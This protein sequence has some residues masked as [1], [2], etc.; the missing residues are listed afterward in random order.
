MVLCCACLNHEV[1]LE[2]AYSES[3]FYVERY[4]VKPLSELDFMRCRWNV[5]HRGEPYIG[6]GHWKI[7][8]L[9]KYKLVSQA[10]LFGLF[11]KHW[12]T[13]FSKM[14]CPAMSI[15]QMARQKCLNDVYRINVSQY[16]LDF[17]QSISNVVK[18]E[19]LVNFF[20]E[21]HDRLAC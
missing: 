15:T 14:L 3:V 16:F 5:V 13:F 6:M 11:I 20:I 9:V 1:W 21:M 10:P 17:C 8:C 18:C 7:S 12:M 19:N 2:V 4:S